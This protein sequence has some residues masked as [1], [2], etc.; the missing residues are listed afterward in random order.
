MDVP[1]LFICYNSGAGNSFLWLQ[2]SKY[3]GLVAIYSLSY[4]FF[5]TPH[6]FPPF[7]FLFLV[8]SPLKIQPLSLAQGHTDTGKGARCEQRLAGS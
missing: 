4:C 5:S 3:V 7:P 6:F 8:S 2:N 1:K